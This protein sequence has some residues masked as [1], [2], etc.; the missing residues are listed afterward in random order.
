MN[1]VILLSLFFF[2]FAFAFIPPSSMILS[3]VAENAGAG[4][5]QIEQELTFESA[6]APL[7]IKEIWTIESESLMRVSVRGTKELDGKISFEILYA[8]GLRWSAKNGDRNSSS[9]PP[10][11]FEKLFLS[12]T[13]ENLGNFMS[14]YKVAPS[15]FWNQKTK[16]APE[17]YIRLSRC[18]EFIC[19][20]F[21]EPTKENIDAKS[22]QFW[23]E[24]DQFVFRKITTPKNAELTIEQYGSY[25][26][27][28]KFP[29]TR[30]LQWGTNIVNI[31]TLQVGIKTGKTDLQ[32]AQL[33]TQSIFDLSSDNL[34]HK[35][36]IEFYSRFR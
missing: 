23:I 34:T 10:E 11:L 8:G 5:Y 29:K 21:G 35:A 2:H 20:A 28:L 7:V 36:I 33:K 9:I 30:S 14:A 18:L 12:R 4:T 6:E 16:N 1:F 13:V 26:K 17:A 25:P 22:P 31:Q 3:R 32:P 19:W 15:Q 24:Q 27:G